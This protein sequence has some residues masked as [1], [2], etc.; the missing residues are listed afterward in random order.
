[1]VSGRLEMLSLSNA[2]ELT[3]TTHYFSTH[4]CK[5]GLTT[6]SF[7]FPDFFLLGARAWKKLVAILNV[8]GWRKRETARLNASCFCLFIFVYTQHA[9]D[10]HTRL[11]SSRDN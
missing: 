5:L 3:R 11:A 8:G 7:S 4:G 9:R 6:C 10:L 1:M 2:R